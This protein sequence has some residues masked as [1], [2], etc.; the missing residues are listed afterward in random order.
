MAG[1]TRRTSGPRPQQQARAVQVSPPV[2]DIPPETPPVEPAE[3]PPGEVA[4]PVEPPPFDAD[5][6][7]P[8]QSIRAH[9]PHSGY[10]SFAYGHRSFTVDPETDLIVAETG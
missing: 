2:V 8:G 3:V 9:V 1:Q 7:R 5:D 10:T 4:A 6:P